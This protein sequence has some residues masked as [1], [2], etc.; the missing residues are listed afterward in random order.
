[1][2]PTAPPASLTGRYL[3]FFVTKNCDPVWTKLPIERPVPLSPPFDPSPLPEGAEFDATLGYEPEGEILAPHFETVRQGTDPGR[4]FE[5]RWRC[6]TCATWPPGIEGLA[7]RRPCGFL[8][9]STAFGSTCCGLI[10]VSDVRLEHGACRLQGRS[11][12]AGWEARETLEPNDLRHVRG[13]GLGDRHAAR[14]GGV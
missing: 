4:P 14:A 11:V 10:P 2:N 9:A 13:G 6:S 8:G 7:P 3:S 5:R 12:Q 1:M